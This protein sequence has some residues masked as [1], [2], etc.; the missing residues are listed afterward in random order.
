MFSNKKNMNIGVLQFIEVSKSKVIHIIAFWSWST[1][2]SIVLLNGSNIHL[3][4][5]AGNSLTDAPISA[6]QT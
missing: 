5:V 3:M 2:I 6:A 1:N 4:L